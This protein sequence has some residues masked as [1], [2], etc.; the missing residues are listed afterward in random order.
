MHQRLLSHRVRR[1][2]PTFSFRQKRKPKSGGEFRFS[3]PSLLTRGHSRAASFKSGAVCNS[4]VTETGLDVNAD[5]PDNRS[6][7]CSLMSDFSLRECP[8]CLTRQPLNMFAELRSCEH[9][10]CITCMI[11]Y[12]ELEISESRVNIHCPECNEMIH[13][14][15]IY[16]LLADHPKLIEKYEEFSVRRVLMADQDTRWCPAPDCNYAVIASGCAACPKLRCE[17]TNC[18]TLFCYHCKMTWHSNQTCD[19]AR[20]QRGSFVT[21]PIHVDMTVKPLSRISAGDIKACPRCKTYIVK[22]N[23][24]SCNHMICALCGVEF[25]WL[26][27]KEISDLHYLSPSGCTFWGKKPWSRKKKLIWQLGMLLGAPV[28]ITLIAG[29]AVPAIVFGVPVW[30]GRKVH[31]RLKDSGKARRR[32]AVTGS[33]IGSVIMSPLLASLAISVGVPIL[34]AYVYGVV[35]L[36]LC[37]NGSC[38]VTASSSGVRLDLDDNI[39]AMTVYSQWQLLAKV[40]LKPPLDNLMVR[41][42]FDRLYIDSPY[43]CYVNHAALLLRH[44]VTS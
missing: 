5:Q 31:N 40:S 35:P 13:P 22:M 41:C 14:N 15:D 26:C 44:F 16:T 19:E 3:F 10:T 39:L 43:M 37:R 28:G 7:T 32:F 23:D 21:L 27:L 20:A 36:S 38:G 6:S 1:S 11:Q 25:C 17:R 24:G 12:L 9:R 33:V 42:A 2:S 4:E 30:I 18:G 29:L 34:L 8:V